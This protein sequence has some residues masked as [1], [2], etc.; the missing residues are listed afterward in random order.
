MREPLIND[1]SSGCELGT[2]RLARSLKVRIE[3]N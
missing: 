1:G 2:V 3:E